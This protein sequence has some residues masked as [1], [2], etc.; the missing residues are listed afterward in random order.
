MICTHH[1]EGQTHVIRVCQEGDSDHPVAEVHY[2]RRD[3]APEMILTTLRLLILRGAAWQVREVLIDALAAADCWP[4]RDGEVFRPVA[5]EL[6]VRTV[7]GPTTN[8]VE[9]LTTSESTP[10]WRE[11]Q[12]RAELGHALTEAA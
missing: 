8:Q 10:W 7:V 4:D 9:V 11:S 6:N 3:D 2:A 5:M 12:A 1:V